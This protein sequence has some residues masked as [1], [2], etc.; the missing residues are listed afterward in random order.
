MTIKEINQK[1]DAGFRIPIAGLTKQQ[2]DYYLG[3]AMSGEVAVDANQNM[4]LT[5]TPKG[6]WNVGKQE[7]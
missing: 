6:E 2:H 5:N 7:R 1:L 4:F 3:R